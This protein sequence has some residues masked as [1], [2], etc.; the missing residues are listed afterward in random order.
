MNQHYRFR[1]Y[2][3]L[4]RL[5]RPV[6]SVLLLWPTLWAVWLAGNGHPSFKLVILFTVGTFLMR[7]LGCVANDIADRNFDG[8]VERTKNRPLVTGAVTLQ[9]ALGLLLFLCFLALCLILQFNS[10]TIKLAFIG[11]VLTFIYPYTKRF[12]HWPQGVIG[13]AFSW[14]IPMAFAAQ[15]NQVPAIAWLLFI[16]A[17]LWPLGYDTMYAMVDR[18]DDQKIGVKSTALLLGKNDRLFVA[19]LQ[20]SFIVLLAYLGYWFKLN[21]FF[22]VGLSFASGLLLYQQYLIKDREPK[23]CFKA[24]FNNTWVGAFIFLAFFLGIRSL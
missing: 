13:L 6:G 14:G 1:A 19:V 22:Y 24:F 4:L 17:S 16:T 11:L 15:T 9:E 5:H 21:S 18:H 10:L 2:A 3:H 12:T 8:F 20:F 23:R 7:G